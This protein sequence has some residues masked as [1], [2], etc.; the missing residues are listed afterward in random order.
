MDQVTLQVGTRDERG[1]RAARRMRREGLVPAIVYGKDRDPVS[2]T[3][4]SHA[5]SA[6]LRTEAGLNAV[7]NLDVDG[8]G[9]LTVAREI[10]RHPVRGHITHL[11]FIKVSLDEEIQADVA[12]EFLGTPI[13]VLEEGGVAETVATSVLIRALPTEIP[14]SIE[15]DIEPLAIGDTLKI[16]DLPVIEGVEYLEDAERPIVTILAPR[17]IEEEEPEE[18][19]E[20]R[21]LAEGEEAPEAGAEDDSD[22]EE[23][24]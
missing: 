18:D 10:Q 14:S 22:A 12:I 19:L 4:A 16:S 2:V 5:L 23:R 11:D 9:V 3:V 8:D 7:I 1:T 17:K 15:M 13:G 6:A 21:E 20:G 24:E